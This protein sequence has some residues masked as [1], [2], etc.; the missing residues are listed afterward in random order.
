MTLILII[1]M[2]PIIVGFLG[3]KIAYQKTY[4]IGPSQV[5]SLSWP[6]KQILNYYN[7]LPKENRP[8]PDIVPMLRALDIKND[9]VNNHFTHHDYD[10]SRKSWDCCYDRQFCMG[11]EYHKLRE[12]IHSIQAS[13]KDQQL[14]LKMKGVEGDL[15]N[16]QMLTERLREEREIIDS[17]TKE[18]T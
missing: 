15:E 11:K 13:I 14:A 16:V 5:K 9:G 2:I 1:A 17:V 7:Q 6:S 10:S 3:R 18:L 4:G 8:L 12:N